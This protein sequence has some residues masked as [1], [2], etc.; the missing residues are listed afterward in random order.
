[1]AD[2]EE[3]IKAS[4]VSK[5]YLERQV[6]DNLIVDLAEYCIEWETIAT[7][8]GTTQAIIRAIDE[9]NRRTEMKRLKMLQRWKQAKSFRATYLVLLQAL[10]ECKLNDA[11]YQMCVFLKGK[12]G[13][14][15]LDHMMPHS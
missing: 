1:M 14:L 2:I 15:E 7:R 8:L 6:S 3:T 12:E 13:K 4:G 11:A 10:H 9:D 5:S